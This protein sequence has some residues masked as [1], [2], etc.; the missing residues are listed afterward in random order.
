MLLRLLLSLLFCSVLLGSHSQEWKFSFIKSI[1]GEFSFF[2]S[3]DLGNIYTVSQNKLIKRDLNGKLL[4]DYSPYI[5]GDISFVDAGDPFKIL[6][7]YED[8]G[9]IEWLDNTLSSVS[10]IYLSE[11]GMELASLACSSY[12]NG[13]WL[14]LPPF[15]QLK[16][17]DQFLE[18]SDNSGNLYKAAG[19]EVDPNY[20]IERD[21]TI[22]LN[23]PS[24]G[25]II[26]DKYGTFN[27]LIG[28]KGLETF[29]VFS[30]KI[31][32]MENQQGK[33]LDP[34]INEEGII[35]LPV[36]D[37]LNFRLSAGTA[38][39]RLFIL[40]KDKLMIYSIQ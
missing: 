24:Y 13:I 31:V 7:F 9:L 26:L 14:Y 38:E 37:V 27:K 32:F 39:K 2:T 8:F 6:L 25:I 30:R 11:I 34:K 36:K 40:L 12:Q 5:N 28:I 35:D 18:T 33:I 1:D 22:Y 19:I 10:Q 20:L 21:N 3:D 29:Q 23:D 4:Y 15:L 16:R 17:L